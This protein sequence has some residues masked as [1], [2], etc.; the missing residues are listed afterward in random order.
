MVGVGE[1]RESVEEYIKLNDS[2]KCHERWNIFFA[3]SRKI[4]GLSLV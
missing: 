1:Q 4:E 3:L 2:F